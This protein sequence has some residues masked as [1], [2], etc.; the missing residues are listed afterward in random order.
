METASKVGSYIRQIYLL[1]GI[2]MC[3]S[4][5]PQVEDLLAILKHEVSTKKNK[6]VDVLHLAS[7]IVRRLSGTQSSTGS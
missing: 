7:Q 3:T 4:H 5:E 1:L 6:N 2:S